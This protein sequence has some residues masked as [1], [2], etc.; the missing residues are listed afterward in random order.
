M[1]EAT[2]EAATLEW[3][4]ALGYGV[5][6]GP[7]MRTRPSGWVERCVLKDSGKSAAIA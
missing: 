2:V 7:E 3:L 5:L 1:N 4:E 6:R